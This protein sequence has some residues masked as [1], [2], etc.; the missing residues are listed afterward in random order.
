MLRKLTAV[1]EEASRKAGEAKRWE[2]RLTAQSRY[3]TAGAT[4]EGC[5]DNLRRA[6]A[7][8]KA[9]EEEIGELE[10]ELKAVQM[11]GK[12]LVPR[13]GPERDHSKQLDL[14]RR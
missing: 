3:Q 11:A 13:P 10:E 5:R 9:L 1:V 6:D 14:F 7:W 2:E 4:V 8:C 12:K